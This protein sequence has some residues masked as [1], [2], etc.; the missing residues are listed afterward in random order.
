MC[1]SDV[2]SIVYIILVYSF[3]FYILYLFLLPVF[4]IVYGIVIYLNLFVFCI[5]Y[6]D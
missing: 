5:V 1:K 4:H 6:Y 3:S 2:N